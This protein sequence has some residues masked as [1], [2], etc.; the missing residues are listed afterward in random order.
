[1]K[2]FLQQTIGDLV[3]IRSHSGKET[4]L[5]DY[6]FEHLT[7]SGLDPKRDEDDNVW[8][9]VGPESAPILHVNAHMDT[10]VPVDGWKTDPYKPHVDGDLLYGLG[11]TDCKAGVASI[12]WLAP[13][14]EPKVRVI[15]SCTVCEEGVGHSKANGSRRMAAMGGR[16]AITAEPSCHDDGPGIG[17]GTQGHARAFVDFRGKAAHSSTP[18]RGENAILHAARFCLAVEELNAGFEKHEIRPGAVSRASAAATLIEG[19][20]LSNIIPDACRVTVSRRLAPGDTLDAFRGELDRMLAGVP[21]SYEAVSDGPCAVADLDGPLLAA[22]ESALTEVT[23]EH[24]CAFKRGRTDAV[25]YAGA[26]MDTLTIGPGLVGQS[27]AA[28]EHMNLAA[29]AACLRVMELTINRLGE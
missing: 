1:M 24:R 28:N 9:A 25:I 2:D 5:A 3:A 14:V 26:G 20:R 18:E 17:I 16:W 29:G 23:G 15:F 13:R 6:V 8:L 19:G 27:H 12:L 4:Q 11:S 22:A 10:V 7:Q 21:A